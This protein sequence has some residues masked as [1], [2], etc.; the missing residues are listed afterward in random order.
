VRHRRLTTTVRAALAAAALALPAADLAAQEVRVP[1]IER[2]DAHQP[3]APLPP[4]PIDLGTAVRIALDRSPGLAFARE[5][6]RAA[7]GR[8][9]QA[10]GVFDT[11]LRFS[12][13][14]SNTMQ[15]MTPGLRSRERDKRE[16][17]QIIADGFTVLN[18][19]LRAQLAAAEIDAPRCPPALTSLIDEQDPLN[20]AAFDRIRD[21]LET[22]L[23]GVDRGLRGVI[24]PELREFGRFFNFADLCSDEL[25]SR[26]GS[27]R[28]LWEDASLFGPIGLD[29]ILSDFTQFPREI[30]LF[31]TE[32]SEAIAARA[33]LGLERLGPVP[34]GEL[35]QSVSFDASLSR[36]FHNGLILGADV[37]IRSTSHHFHDKPL[38]PSFGGFEIPN[39]FP[40]SVSASLSTPLGRGRG[41]ASVTAPMRAAE[42]LMAA[43]RDDLRHDAAE[44]VLRT[45]MA[46]LDLLAAQE[47]LAR[48]EESAARQG[49]MADLTGRLVAAGELPAAENNRAQ[50]RQAFVATSVSQARSE[51]L[52]ARARL[53]NAMGVTVDAI[54]QAPRA[55]GRLAETLPQVPELAPLL[56]GPL[57]LRRDLAALGRMREA[58]SVL[59]AA[60]RAD[61][62]GRFDFSLNGGFSNVY[63][64][65]LFFFLPDER[66]PIISPEPQPVPGRG[67]R[68]ADPRGFYRSITG[69]WEP[70][71]FASMT[72]DLPLGNRGARGRLQQSEASLQQAE[73]QLV[74]LERTARENLVATDGA[75]RRAAE[76]VADLRVAIEAGG[77]TLDTTLA[78][79]E[80]GEVTLADT[81]RTEEEVLAD[82]IELI[83]YLQS[84]YQTLARLR[85]EAGTLVSFDLEGDG[86]AFRFDPSEFVAPG[87]GGTR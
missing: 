32:L 17:L 62:R 54:E 87:A 85:F 51:V 18:T 60:G 25:A 83:G 46:Y 41:R 37:S 64:S 9:Q 28:R 27:N 78:Q 53:A 67:V 81:L 26:R 63:E 52:N 74:N 6:L 38:D 34:L 3:Q 29:R 59:A 21:P 77:R 75:L 72:I 8:W 57:T 7:T 20:F 1:S 61:L 13:F 56:A 47:R 22:T 55:E 5:D 31:G 40:S 15:P 10:T 12:S 50:A 86:Q 73:I 39:R 71:V 44:Q 84:F 79:F 4:G 48:L 14:L 36:P 19:D 76:A 42:H 82:R 58:S 66:Q 43:R 35:R 11:R 68:L 49:R 33:R 69:R 65:P 80:I 70:F 16:Q 30:L 24:I 23:T 45:V 2:R